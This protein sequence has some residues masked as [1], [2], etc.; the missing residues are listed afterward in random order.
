MFRY[1]NEFK[2]KIIELVRQGRTI[3]SIVREFKVTG[4]TIRKWV[5][6]LVTDKVKRRK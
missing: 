6:E 1:S 5:T 3:S 2:N 4:A